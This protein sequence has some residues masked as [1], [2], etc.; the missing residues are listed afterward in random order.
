MMVRERS[1]VALWLRHPGVAE[2]VFARF[3]GVASVRVLALFTRCATNCGIAVPRV[4][5]KSAVRD[6]RSLTAVACVSHS[7]QNSKRVSFERGDLRT[8][9]SAEG[10]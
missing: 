1:K 4:M 2:G 10:T 8:C 5:S 7:E 9:T 3:W 6:W